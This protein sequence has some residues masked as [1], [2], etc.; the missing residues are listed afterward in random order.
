MEPAEAPRARVIDLRSDTVT[1]PTRAMMEAMMS[2]EVS[3]ALCTLI[4]ALSAVPS[5][6]GVASQSI[7]LLGKT[8]FPWLIVL[9]LYI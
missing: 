5:R 6:C 8:R 1:K 7:A 4:C 3:T 2:S 9:A